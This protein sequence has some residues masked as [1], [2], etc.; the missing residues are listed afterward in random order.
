[1]DSFLENFVNSLYRKNRE[2]IL[3]SSYNWSIIFNWSFGKASFSSTT[4]Q[5][6]SG[7]FLWSLSSLEELLWNFLRKWNLKSS[8]WLHTFQTLSLQY[9]S[10]TSSITYHTDILMLLEML[11]H[12]IILG[13]EVARKNI[14]V[15]YFYAGRT[16]NL[17]VHKS[18]CTP[19]KY[20][21][22]SNKMLFPTQLSLTQVPKTC[23]LT[24]EGWERGKFGW[25]DIVFLP[26]A[27]FKS[28]KLY[29][30]NWPCWH[31]QGTFWGPG[32]DI[33]KC[34]YH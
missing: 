2:F 1:M 17:P 21:S 26:Q 14:S 4:Y 15:P 29:K 20:I 7:K 8:F 9:D 30:N 13:A 12:I 10:H 24:E 33:L 22:K 28:I 31:W 18:D 5:H 16:N 3:S 34:K 11:H 23:L 25:K 32:A 27:R 19:C 6:M